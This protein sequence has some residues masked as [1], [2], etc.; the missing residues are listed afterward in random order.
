[1]IRI[2][3]KF[4]IWPR[5]IDVRS[6]TSSRRKF[7]FP[8]LSVN[9]SCIGIGGR[10]KVRK[11]RAYACISKRDTRLAATSEQIKSN[12]LRHGGDNESGDR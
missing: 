11:A 4:L 2:A 1:M 7:Y 12:K 8:Y 9:A 10:M 6:M 3:N 5:S